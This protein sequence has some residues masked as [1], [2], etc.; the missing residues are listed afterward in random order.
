MR[1]WCR[2]IA[3]GLAMLSIPAA[4]LAEGELRAV[5]SDGSQKLYPG[6]KVVD[7]ASAVYFIDNA[8]HQMVVVVK[9][10][11]SKEG[12]LQLC[13]GTGV[14]WDRYGVRTDLDASSVT[15]YYNGTQKS[16]GIKNSPFTLTP[17]TLKV[18]IVTSKGT[19]IT[20]FG[21]VDSTSVP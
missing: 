3:L 16:V 2:S 4:A 19:H 11:C 9:S 6:L 7:S 5:Y 1:F 12:V 8:A 15:L 18:D 14:T 13:T 20:G 21:F 17:N 10:A